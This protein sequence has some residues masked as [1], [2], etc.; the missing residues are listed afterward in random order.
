M[1]SGS[2]R[3]MVKNVSDCT[4]I[5]LGKAG[6]ENLIK[7]KATVTNITYTTEGVQVRYVSPT[8]VVE[9]SV[10]TTGTLEDAYIAAVGGVAR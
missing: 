4:W 3:G 8:P 7:E 9:G 2:T 5:Y 1:Y 6:E 10:L